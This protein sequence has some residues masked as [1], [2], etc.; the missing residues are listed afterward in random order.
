MTLILY[1]NSDRKHYL[2]QNMDDSGLRDCVSWE[3]ITFLYNF[4]KLVN[5]LD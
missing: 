2:R 4:S 3:K 1:Q 5:H